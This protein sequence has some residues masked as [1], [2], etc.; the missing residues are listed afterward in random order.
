MSL[1]NQSRVVNTIFRHF[2]VPD[3]LQKVKDYF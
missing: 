3:Q 2:I 1:E